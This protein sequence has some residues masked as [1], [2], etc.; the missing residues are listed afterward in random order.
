MQDLSR[1]QRATDA[2]CLASARG[3]RKEAENL[4]H[5]ADTA[6]LTANQRATLLREAEAAERQAR[7][8]LDA[9]AAH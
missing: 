7:W 3:W 5:N 9:I 4:R 6:Y 1:L 8:W 2:S